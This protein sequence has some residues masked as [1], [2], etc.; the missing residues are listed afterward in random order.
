MALGEGHGHYE[1]HGDDHVHLV[2]LECGLVEEIPPLPGLR[3]VDEIE[4]FEVSHTHLEL[5]GTCAACRAKRD[6]TD[7]GPDR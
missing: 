1:I 4:G 6:A 2:C 5:I 3:T 7:V